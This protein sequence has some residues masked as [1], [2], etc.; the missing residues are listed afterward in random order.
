MNKRYVYVIM[1]G[2]IGD[3]D[4]MQICSSEKKAKQIIKE[5]LKDPYERSAE[6]DYEK[7]EVE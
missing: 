5:L 3:R 2:C 6:P 1:S 7:W 4:I